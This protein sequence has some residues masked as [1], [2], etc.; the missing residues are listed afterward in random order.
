MRKSV[1]LILIVLWQEITSVATE[2]GVRLRVPWPPLDAV[3]PQSSCG[4]PRLK[5]HLISVEYGSDNAEQ[6]TVGRRH[7]PL[8]LKSREENCRRHRRVPGELCPDAFS[9]IR[10]ITSEF[11]SAHLTCCGRMPNCSPY[12]PILPTSNSIAARPTAS[13]PTLTGQSSW[14]LCPSW[15][16]I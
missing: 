9:S 2:L 15:S 1:L 14:E 7:R 16:F 11:R 6:P 10:L 4:K 5:S 3:P 13:H 8:S 12:T